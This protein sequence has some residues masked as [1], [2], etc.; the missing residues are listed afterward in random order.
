MT[1]IRL[2]SL[3]DLDLSGGDL[4]LID[5]KEELVRQRLLNK[6]RTFT[7][8]LFTNVLYGIDVDLVF[9]KDTQGLLDQ[10]LK[11]LI[12]STKGIISLV[13]F[14]SE[15]NLK[16]E[17]TCNFT[18][19]IETGEIVGIA[20]ITLGTKGVVS[21]TGIWRDGLWDYSGIWNNDEIWGS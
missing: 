7:G 15:V 16:R 20:G 3:N 4:A 6:L 21:T 19:E 8:T 14:T 5:N 2:N 12:S 17:Y 11:D 1:D 9:Q 13:S 10:H 18:Y